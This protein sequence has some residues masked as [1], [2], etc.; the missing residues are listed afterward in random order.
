M[1]GTT[2]SPPVTALF[3]RGYSGIDPSAGAHSRRGCL[4][5]LQARRER[6]W[7]R[8]FSGLL[9]QPDPERLNLL[10]RAIRLRTNEV[11]RAIR[12][13]DLAAGYRKPSGFDFPLDQA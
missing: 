12:G 4:V 5:A 10:E 2:P 13:H 3:W 1:F 8:R 11:I 6:P 7:L 9:R